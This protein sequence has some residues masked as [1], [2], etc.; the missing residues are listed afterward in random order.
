ME[1]LVLASGDVTPTAKLIVQLIDD[2]GRPYVLVIWPAEPT[3]ISPARYDQVIARAFRTLA[4]SS[5]E[6]AARRRRRVV[7]DEEE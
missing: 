2:D 4:N 7:D 5:V 1:K 3:R 6:L